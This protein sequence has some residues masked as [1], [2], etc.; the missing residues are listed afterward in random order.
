[1]E[2]VILLIDIYKTQVFNLLADCLLVEAWGLPFLSTII[3]N[4]I[5]KL[6]RRNQFSLLVKIS[7]SS[8]D[9]QSNG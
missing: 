8:L 9:S 3:D 4:K 2:D 7:S 5:E 6:V 1:M